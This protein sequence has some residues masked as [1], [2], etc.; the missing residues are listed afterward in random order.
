MVNGN[1]SQER[2]VYLLNILS[3]LPMHLMAKSGLELRKVQSGLMGKIFTTVSAED[4]Y[5]MIM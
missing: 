5:R 1:Y 2:K 3:A 4:G